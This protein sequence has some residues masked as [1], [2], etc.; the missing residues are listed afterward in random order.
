[1]SGLSI[2]MSFAYGDGTNQDQS[3]HVKSINSVSMSSKSNNNSKK[4]S[5]LALNNSILDRNEIISSMPLN[6]ALRDGFASP[7]NSQLHSNRMRRGLMD[8]EH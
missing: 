6:G 3:F 8:I 4:N 1:M 5:Y 2:K 7:S